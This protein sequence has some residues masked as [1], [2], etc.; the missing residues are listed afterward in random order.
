M[1]RK[2]NV[3]LDIEDLLPCLSVEKRIPE[4]ALDYVKSIKVIKRQNRISEKNLKCWF[5]MKTA[6]KLVLTQINRHNQKL[7]CTKNRQYQ[8]S[9][10]SQKGQNICIIFH[11]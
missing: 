10:C 3:Q 11:G 4:G 1:Y 8:A 5:I 7:H 2:T 6:V 9:N